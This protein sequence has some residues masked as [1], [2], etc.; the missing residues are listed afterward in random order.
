[1]TAPI[2]AVNYGQCTCNTICQGVLTDDIRPKD[3][4]H[5]PHPITENEGDAGSQGTSKAVDCG[6]K[7]LHGRIWIAQHF[8][9]QVSGE[10]AS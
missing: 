9:E 2:T 10:N 4:A 8:P 3:R 5:P 7:T 1:M 6:K